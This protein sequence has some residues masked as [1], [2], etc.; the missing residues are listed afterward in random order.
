MTRG[1]RR[2]MLSIAG[3]M[4]LATALVSAGCGVKAPPR[5]PLREPPAEPAAAA[6]PGV[7]A[8]AAPASDATR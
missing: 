5:P 1:G 8:P 2:L 3:A 6:P 4:G 7:N